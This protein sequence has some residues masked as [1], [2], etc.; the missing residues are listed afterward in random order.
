MFCNPLKGIGCKRE[1]KWMKKH[2]CV[3]LTHGNNLLLRSAIKNNDLSLVDYLLENG[4]DPLLFD[5][6]AYKTIVHHAS[7]EMIALILQNEVEEEVERLLFVAT[8][9]DRL[10]QFKFIF[11][12]Y[13]FL[14]DFN[15]K[16]TVFENAANCNSLKVM[17]WFLT[18]RFHV[19]DG[20]TIRCESAFNFSCVTV[21][22]ECIHAVQTGNF[23]MLQNFTVFIQGYFIV[24][25]FQVSGPI[26]RTILSNLR[27]AF[28]WSVFKQRSTCKRWLLTHLQFVHDRGQE[29]GHFL[30]FD[31]DLLDGQ[32]NQEAPKDYSFLLCSLIQTSNDNIEALNL[33]RELAVEFPL[34]T[35]L[36][37]ETREFILWF[38]IHQGQLEFFKIVINPLRGNCRAISQPFRVPVII[39]ELYSDTLS[40]SI[41]LKYNGTKPIIEFSDRSPN[42]YELSILSSTYNFNT[43]NK[44]KHSGMYQKKRPVCY[45]GF[46]D[47]VL[48]MIETCPPLLQENMV[49]MWK[50]IMVFLE[51]KIDGS[52]EFKKLENMLPAT[53]DWEFEVNG[54]LIW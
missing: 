30:E 18:Y 29:M 37:A 14:H 1:I 42:S 27:E 43:I 3:D 34:A 26:V 8:V 46:Y 51:W 49:K 17:K 54:E 23:E 5:A 53:L 21:S 4:A 6:C 15:V 41:P 2:G 35:C 31:N 47:A 33:F 11:K 20:L 38:C 24:S 40:N 36:N 28:F 9:E 44:S 45:Q 48:K 16:K 13:I 32:V 52:G 50:N 19:R 25:Q 22:Y 12:T 39:S 7:N 10:C